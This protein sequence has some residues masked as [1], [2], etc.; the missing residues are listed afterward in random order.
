VDETNTTTE[1]S[2]TTASTVTTAIQVDSE[3]PTPVD[4]DNDPLESGSHVEVQLTKSTKTSL[5]QA[6]ETDLDKGEEE[7]LDQ[8]MGVD[9]RNEDNLQEVIE[10]QSDHEQEMDVDNVGGED[11]AEVQVYSNTDNKK[12]ANTTTDKP[13]SKK[14]N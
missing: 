1:L 6:H 8:E 4:D 11:E 2:N 3:N 9:G 10:E 7:V 13:S 5:D 14:A 12:R